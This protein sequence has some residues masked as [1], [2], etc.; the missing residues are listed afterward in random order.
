MAF[1]N[2][3]HQLANNIR[4]QNSPFYQDTQQLPCRGHNYLSN[5]SVADAGSGTQSKINQIQNSNNN[6]NNN[7][8]TNNNN[9]INN[10][11]LYSKIP[12]EN[13]FFW[14]FVLLIIIDYIWIGLLFSDHYRVLYS[15]IQ[16]QELRIRFPSVL[17]VYLFLTLLIVVFV[18]PNIEKEARFQISLNQNNQNGELQTNQ[19]IKIS[20]K[21]GGLL[22]LAVYAVY[23]FTNHAVFEYYSLEATLIDTIWGGFLIFIVSACVYMITHKRN[24][25]NEQFIS[26]QII[27]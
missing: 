7:N 23:N 16:N 8:N 15:E 2:N 21:Y 17:I 13:L 12:F 4:N 14:T 10:Q 3:Q 20:A 22:G 24:V 1:L 25:S 27:I 6:N 5:P 18:I 19:I 9:I 26:E 11:L